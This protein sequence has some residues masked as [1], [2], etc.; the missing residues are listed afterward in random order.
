MSTIMLCIDSWS[1]SCWISCFRVGNVCSSVNTPYSGDFW[2]VLIC[3]F[4]FG[5]IFGLIF[6]CFW[7]IL[8][9]EYLGLWWIVVV[10]IGWWLGSVECMCKKLGTN[11]DKEERAR[12]REKLLKYY[13][14]S[15]SNRVYLH[16]Y[17]STFVY[18]QMFRKTNASVFCVMLCKFFH[19]LHFT[20][21]NAIALRGGK[22]NWNLFA[23]PN[24]LNY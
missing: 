11:T 20:L 3:D 17:C 19:F 23:H 9:L 7:L 2:S 12:E 8:W 15:Y 1:I 16:G 14:Q 6:L 24:P 10:V 21:T 22:I 13:I 4:W 5:L 18:L